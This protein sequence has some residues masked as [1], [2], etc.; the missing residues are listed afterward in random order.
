MARARE[1][2]DDEIVATLLAR[3]CDLEARLAAG[4]GP[5]SPTGTSPTLDRLL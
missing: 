5:A 1:H 2:A 3:I 4:S